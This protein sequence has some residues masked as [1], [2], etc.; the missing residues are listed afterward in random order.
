MKTFRIYFKAPPEAFT[1]AW[2]RFI[3]VAAP[4]KAEAEEFARTWLAEFMI[5]SR[6]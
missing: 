5:G 3:E 4:T 6:P 1:C 2:P